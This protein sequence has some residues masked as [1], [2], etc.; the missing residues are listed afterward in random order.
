M[1]LKDARRMRD[2]A[3]ATYHR[4]HHQQERVDLTQWWADY[5]DTL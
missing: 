3:R 5:L 2:G 1:N 4:G